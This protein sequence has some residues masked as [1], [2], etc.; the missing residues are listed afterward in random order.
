M[1]AFFAIFTLFFV[2]ALAG[3]TDEQKAKLAAYK[4]ECIKESGVDPAV[5]QNAKE[6]KADESDT[7][8]ACF[9]SCL[10]KKIGIMNADGTI[11]EE[12]ARSKVPDSVPKDKAEEIIN[13]CKTM[14]GANDCETGLKVMK[15]YMEK[16]TFSIL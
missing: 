1:K 10:L 3:L 16:K 11:N 5:V 15:C 2:G 6:G 9:S 14:K 13:E 8:L 7:K 12:V 4:A